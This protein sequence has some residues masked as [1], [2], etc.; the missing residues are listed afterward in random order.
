S[1]LEMLM[2]ITVEDVRP[3]GRKLFNVRYQRVRYVQEIDGERVEFDS[4]ARPTAIP[5]EVAPY[6]RL[7]DNGFSF[8]LGPDNRIDDLVGFDEFLKRCVQDVPPAR[9]GEVLAQFARTSS[10]EGI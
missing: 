1:S 10:E 7:V 9:R 2:A 5:P 6:R 8:W 4:T 3:D